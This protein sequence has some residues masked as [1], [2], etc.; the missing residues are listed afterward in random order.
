MA[1]LW[2]RPQSEGDR[3][4]QPRAKE[5]SRRQE[6]Q[7]REDQDDCSGSEPK[8]RCMAADHRLREK[9]IDDVG[10]SWTVRRFTSSLVVRFRRSC[11]IS[12]GTFTML[13]SRP[14]AEH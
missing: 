14:L 9:E 1:R 13:E 3:H 2:P 10:A 11:P 6:A 4:G 7:E 12:A 5:E 8:A